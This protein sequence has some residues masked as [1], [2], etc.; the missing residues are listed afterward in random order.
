[1]KKI[2]LFFSLFSSLIPFVSAGNFIYPLSQIAAPSCRFQTWGGLGSEC[3]MALPK[4][5][6][7]DYDKYKDDKLMRRVY[8]VLW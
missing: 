7:A 5:T 3:K 4:I 2:I 1:M 6:N 8:S